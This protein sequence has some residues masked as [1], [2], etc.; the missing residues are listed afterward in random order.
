MPYPRRGTGG[1][2]GASYTVY[3]KATNSMPAVF[4][5][6]ASRDTY[7]SNNPVELTSVNN[8]PLAIGVGAVAEDP[9]QTN[10]SQWYAYID[11]VWIT[12]VA[13]L[14][15]ATG[16]SAIN[17]VDEGQIP[18]VEGGKLV[19]SGM[20]RLPSG[21]ILAPK[22]FGVE[23]ASVDFG[24]VITVSEQSSFLGIHDNASGNSYVVVDF[25]RNR[26]APS[27]TLAYSDRQKAS[28][29]KLYSLM[30]LRR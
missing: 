14:V 21:Q 23:S 9:S 25:E 28:R 15:G 5:S 8:R 2:G 13:T 7:F 26:D 29:L 18:V 4:T 16:P 24:D 20:Q 11:G 17:D 19:S 6:T 1:G 22:S 12:I 27:K 30:T 3:S 10:V